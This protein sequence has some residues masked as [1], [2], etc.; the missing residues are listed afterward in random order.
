YN[1]NQDRWYA[2]LQRGFFLIAD[3]MAND[4]A[5]QMVVDRLPLLLKD[6]LVWGD[7]LAGE[8]FQER[9][10]LG[11]REL[12]EQVY[13]EMAACGELGLGTTLVLVLVREPLALLAHIG[14]S[15]A[16]RFRDGAL[17]QLTRDHSLVQRLLDQGLISEDDARKA[18]S[19]GGPTR[20]LGQS[21]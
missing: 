7:E 21:G 14:D 5:P 9:L 8:A 6:M 17:Q 19:N 11:L 10:Q 13:E 1:D 20:F 3:G 12:N 4:I 16:Y 2:D 15:R 18:R